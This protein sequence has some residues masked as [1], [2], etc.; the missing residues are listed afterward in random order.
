MTLATK[1]F[2]EL[3]SI[4]QGMGVADVFSMDRN[5]LVQAIELRQ[6]DLSPTP[7]AP[8][9]VR[10]YDA[11]LM[12]K[13]PSKKANQIDMESYLQPL[14]DQGLHLDF[15]NEEEWHM[16]FGKREDTGT[17]RMPLRVVLGCAERLMA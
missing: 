2:H 3:R 10:E 7:D 8:R 11:R 1:S 9:V 13:P 5:Q 4:A 14:L 17:M 12:T 6:K 15:P 16:R